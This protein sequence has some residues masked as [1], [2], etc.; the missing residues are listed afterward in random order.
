MIGE[1]LIIGMSH[2]HGK[3]I[4]EA[5]GQLPQQE[6]RP[7][8]FRKKPILIAAI[9][10]SVGILTGA[11]I[12][13]MVSMRVEDITV[14]APILET[15]VDDDGNTVQIWTE[16]FYEGE[17]VN[18]DEVYDTFLELG[19]YYPQQI[20]E[21]YSMTFVSEGA[22]YQ[23]QSIEY[24][25][26]AGE[27]IRF[28]IYIADDASSVEIYEIKDKTAVLIGGKEGILYEHGEN[29][30]T[31][32]WVHE[33]LGFGFALKTGDDKVDLI[34]M[35]RSVAEGEPLKPTRSEKTVEAIEELGDF[36]LGYLPDGFEELGVL[37]SPIA[38]GGGWYSYVRK[39]YVNR[40]EN[41]RI[42]FEYESYRI[43]TEEGY[44][45]DAKTVCSF[46]IPGYDIMRGI[47]IGDEVEINGMFGIAAET[48]IAWADPET[49]RVFHLHS[50]DI[51][52]ADLMKVAQSITENS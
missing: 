3:Y 26:G 17:E 5:E 41:L 22:P 46:F 13:A 20:P 7:I 28:T 25:N 32:V 44:T 47:V 49:K 39:W 38:D 23:N 40:A 30:R 2:V 31:L 45:D 15:Q 50:K 51:T 16:E 42:Y 9:I 33:D 48:D 24:E 43:I 12:D 10:A 34:A 36:N 19:S 11:A 35:A 6:K 52:G 1:E 18:F 14:Y 4:Q 8:H 29:R 37:G 21:G 27:T